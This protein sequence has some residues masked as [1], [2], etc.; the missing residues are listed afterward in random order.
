MTAITDE[1]LMAYADGMLPQEEMRR[2]A[3]A[4]QETPALV[5]RLQAFGCM[6]DALRQ[7]FAPI[8][9]LPIPQHLLRAVIATNHRDVK[10]KGSLRERLS[11]LL[12]I[13]RYWRRPSGG[14]F[15]P[16]W[17]LAASA[18]LVASLSVGWLL[19][20]RQVASEGAV[21]FRVWGVPVSKFMQ[22]ALDGNARGETAT[23]AGEQ[24]LTVT[25]VA[26]FRARD[27]EWCRSYEKTVVATNDKTVGLACRAASGPWRIKTEVAALKSFF[28]VGEQAQSTEDTNPLDAIAGQHMVGQ[29]L[30]RDEE[31]Q[32]IKL[33]WGALR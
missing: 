2:V 26:S 9:A 28:P 13:H 15:V 19:Q 18:V 21:P 11:E 29:E 25:P 17:T 32:Q 1:T 14:Y 7:P 20:T 12:G 10:P 22:D 8:L 3:L 24:A 6:Q 5:A 16:A 30:S 23:R 31:A 4:L 33:H 27:G